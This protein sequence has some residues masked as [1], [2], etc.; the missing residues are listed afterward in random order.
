MTTAELIRLLKK[1]GCKF[2]RNGSNHDIYKSPITGNEFP[3]GRHPSEEVKT[4]TL[5]T[6]LKQAGI[7]M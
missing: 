6:I 3:V 5:C 7:K 4:P 1:N 2:V